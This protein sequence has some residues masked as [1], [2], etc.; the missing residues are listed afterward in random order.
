VQWDDDRDHGGGGGGD[1]GVTDVV[2]VSAVVDGIVV[3]GTVVVVGC[4]E[5][6][7]DGDGAVVARVVEGFVVSEVVA[8]V[9]CVTTGCVVVAVPACELVRRCAGRGDGVVPFDE[10]VVKMASAI[11]AAASTTMLAMMNGRAVIRR[12]DLGP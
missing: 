12:L 7:G 9:D 11:P 10:R 5:G 6:G 2:V 1:V 8:C 4:V 3:D